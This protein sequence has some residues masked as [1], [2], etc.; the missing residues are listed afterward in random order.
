ME[1]DADLQV[2][3]MYFSLLGING[4]EKNQEDRIEM[5]DWTEMSEDGE[6]MVWERRM[7]SAY[8]MRVDE[9]K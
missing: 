6:Q 7:S 9:G 4:A 3:I 5:S 1:K 8:R 2:M